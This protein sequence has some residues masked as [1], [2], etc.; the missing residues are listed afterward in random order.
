MN[1]LNIMLPVFLV[2]GL[3]Y[4][5]RLLGF[6][7]EDTNAWLSRLVF[8]VAAPLLLFYSTAQNSFDWGTGI[9]ML[10]A[11]G[12]MTVLVTVVVYA[13]SARLTPAR[14]G[15]LTQGA[16]RSNIVFVGLPVV[17]YAYGEP[18]LGPAS[19]L[20][21]FM[22]VVDN[23]LAV[24][25]LTLPHQQHS[26]RDPNLW[27]NTALRI[28]KNPL[29]WGCGGGFLY[30]LLG[31]GL[32]VSIDRSL[33]LIGRTAA[34]LGLLCV[35]ASLEFRKLRSDIP[36]TAVAAII[37]LILYP[38]LIFGTLRKLGL[39]GIDLGVPVMIMA[40]PTA[41]VSYIM[42]REMQGDPQLGAA[43]VIGTTVASMIT[44]LAWLTFLGVG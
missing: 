19:I 30:S 1:V 22:V 10:L 28:A 14:R 2:I 4:G 7:R 5:L 20:I 26:V 27:V 32:P 6:I 12:G 36:G 35:G 43:I 24:L 23:L 34:P 16:L 9:P 42:A 39:E 11:I 21:G 3:G 31:I 25:V 41:V 40:C 37:K 13:G 17:L 29:I 44:L 33:A 15:V 38:A 18:A 8:Y